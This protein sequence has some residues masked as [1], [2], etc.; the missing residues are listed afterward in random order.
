MKR[1]LQWIWQK[2][3]VSTFMAGFFVILPIVITIGIMGWVGALLKTWLGPNSLLGSILQRVGLNYVSNDTL[4][5]VIGWVIVLAV[6]WFVGA[7]V[8][9]AA[10]YRVENFVHEKL[11]QVPV[12]SSIYG[13]VAKVVGML[14]RDE[15]ADMRAMSVVYCEFGMQHGGGFLA[16]LSSEKVYRFSGRDAHIVYIPTSPIPMSGGI[17]FVPVEAVKPVDME[18]E[19]LMQIYLSLGVMSDAVVPEQYLQGQELAGLKANE[20]S[21]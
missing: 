19:H 13:P 3:F 15:E 12:V 7:I 21:G 14:K 5:S 2:G 4:A 16:L 8:K 20:P 18:V 17:V 11:N 10:R 6:I 9:S 1:V